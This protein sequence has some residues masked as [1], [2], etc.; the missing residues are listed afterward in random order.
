LRSVDRFQQRWPV[1]AFP[2]AVWKKFNDDQAG[3]LAALIAYYAFL[4]LFPLLLVLATVLDIALAN[5][6]HL[7]DQLINSALAQ[8][9]VIGPQ[10]N[11][12]LGHIPGTGLPL[13]V[14]IVLLLFGVRGVANAMMNALCTIWGIDRKDRPGFPMSQVWA[15]AL[16][17]T[18]S[19]GF[20]A[21]TFLS[22]LASGAGHWINGTQAHI[23]TIAVSLILNF[24]MF[25]LSFRLATAFRVRW[26]D[27]RT[28]AAIAAV[29]WQVL[30][31]VGGYV[32]SHQL[33][34]SS[35]LYGTF[36]VVLGLIAWLY[37]QAEVTI[38]AAE[39]DVVLARHKWPR[40]LLPDEPD[41]S[42]KSTQLSGKAGPSG[43]SAAPD[44]SPARGKQAV[45]G[46]AERVRQRQPSS[47]IG[48][49]VPNGQADA[50][51]RPA[52]PPPRDG[53]AASDERATGQR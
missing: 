45:P 1:L 9:P 28:G 22:G 31:V 27:L 11:A 34:R 52:V 15:M 46:G 37:L 21:T 47:L 3:N 41:K 49:P 51:A 13:A 18:V 25:W 39:A 44:T 29:S 17:F 5:N 50:G 14:G 2:V 32:V 6:P 4:A 12:K 8:Y 40:P 20:I 16:I 24:G 10:I 48:E 30:Q 19:I 53:P 38:Y 23:G 33:H 35:Q 36:G 7:R 26:R 43:D 42:D